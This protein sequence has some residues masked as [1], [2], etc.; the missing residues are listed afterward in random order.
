MKIESE[1]RRALQRAPKGLCEIAD[2]TGIPRASLYR[3]ANQYGKKRKAGI[4]LRMAETLL[5]YFGFRL[6]PP[7]A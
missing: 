3:F 4:N 5:N 1:L 7:D 6:V 2:D